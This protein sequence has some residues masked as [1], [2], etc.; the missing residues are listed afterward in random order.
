MFAESCSR[1]AV[2]M[3]VA[4]SSSS[5]RDVLETIVISLASSLRHPYQI[6]RKS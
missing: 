4:F 3:I 2:W 1:F 5:A 6:T